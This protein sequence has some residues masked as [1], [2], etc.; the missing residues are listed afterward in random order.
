VARTGAGL[1]HVDGRAG[2]GGGLSTSV[3]EGG[4]GNGR[5]GR[6][7]GEG[8]T[9]RGQGGDGIGLRQWP[10]RATGREGRWPG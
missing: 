5:E 10:L 6:P 9:C 2:A 7:D 1:G 4:A 8:A 3:I